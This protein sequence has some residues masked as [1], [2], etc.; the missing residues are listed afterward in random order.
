MSFFEDA[1][2]VLIP[3]GI[4]NQKIYSVKP[5][6]G[7]GDLTFS[8]A[9]SATRV[10]SDGLIEK[11]RTNLVLYSEQFDNA[12]YTKYSA[13]ITANTTETTDPLGG[14][15]AD[16]IVSANATAGCG[17]ET[18]IPYTSGGEYTVSIYAKY[19]NTAFVQLLAP[20]FVTTEFVNFN[21]QTGVIAGGS[22]ARTPTIT[23]VGNGWYRCSFT[24]VS[25]YTGTTAINVIS[26]VDSASST[27]GQAFT[28]DGVKAVYIFGAQAETGV[29]T[30]YI[31]TTTAA[32]SVGPV[33]GLPRL[34]YLNS[35]CP[36]L[37]LEGQRSNLALYSE[38]FNN[39]AWVP[40]RASVTANVATSPDGY[41]NADKVIENTDNNS[42]GIFQ[43]ITNTSGQQYS[44]SVYAKAAERSWLIIYIS[45]GP[46]QGRF[47]N[48]SNGTLG[49]V[50]SIAPNA[51]SITDV[52]NGWYRCS[53]TYTATDGSSNVSIYTAI[54]DGT[55]SYA[56]DGTS[57]IL[58]YGCQTE[59][60]SYPTSLIPTLGASVTRVAD[61]ASKTGISSLIGQTEGTM[62]V[63]GS[64]AGI[65]PVLIRRT[66][67]ISDGTTSNGVLIQNAANTTTMQFVV[68]NGGIQQVVI[69]KTLAFTFGQ[70]FKAAFA[71]KENDFVAYINGVQVG[72]D[73]SGTV[74]TCSKFAFDR[75]TGTTPH[76]GIINQ[77]LLFKTRLPN[78]SLA[79]LTS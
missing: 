31:A 25:N 28:G 47:F 8:R 66:I 34:D 24:F 41:T 69:N 21:I 73:T 68:V 42:H 2:I 26:L 19:K 72:T 46:G 57:G 59:L 36:K 10:Q 75:G 51:S 45:G 7:T 9:S 4:K 16:I 13:T 40:F 37:L 22:Y 35:T 3:S 65:E 49:G 33:S 77:A 61:A 74:P 11:V 55:D 14:N 70:T 79:E 58:I 18:N 15:A 76:E 44:V 32:V 1:S 6:D 5:T 20:S 64:F 23:S 78:E 63:E 60:G 54:A 30:D 62:F 48:L 29:M 39:A 56:G 53:I 67:S 38:N 17:M 50:F 71:Y 12:A 52:G 27:R 43:A